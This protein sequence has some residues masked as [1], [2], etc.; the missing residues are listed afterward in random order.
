[1]TTLMERPEVRE[2]EQPTAKER[3]QLEASADVK[4]PRWQTF[5]DEV[6]QGKGILMMDGA[7]P[8]KIVEADDAEQ[9]L[10]LAGLLKAGKVTGFVV[11][12]VAGF[13]RG[14]SL[15]AAAM[16]AADLGRLNG[17]EPGI[18]M[19]G[20]SVPELTKENGNIIRT[21]ISGIREVQ[22]GG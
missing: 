6:M 12:S 18:W 16:L 9:A 19:Q 5:S 8:D 13:S 2:A 7:E 22:K 20:E 3:R 21:W 15:M 1:M 14:H 11:Y 10:K 17:K 4:L